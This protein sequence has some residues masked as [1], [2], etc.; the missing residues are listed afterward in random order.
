MQQHDAE[1]GGA[2][3]NGDIQVQQRD[4]SS[5]KVYLSIDHDDQNGI[6]LKKNTQ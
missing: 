1:K 5:A 4:R 3:A 2:Q 6:N